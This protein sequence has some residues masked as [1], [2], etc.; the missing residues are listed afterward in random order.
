MNSFITATLSVFDMEASLQTE[1]EK[2]S[3][4]NGEMS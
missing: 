3:L 4:M 1:V 2:G